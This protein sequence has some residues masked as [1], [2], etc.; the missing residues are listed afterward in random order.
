MKISDT[1]DN[2]VV[3]FSSIKVGNYPIVRIIGN[4]IDH[5]LSSPYIRSM[6][7][8]FEIFAKDSGVCFIS[9]DGR[10]TNMVIGYI[11]YHSK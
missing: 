7:R 10:E 11:N 4:D 9:N 1:N 5:V 8:G 6:Y 2:M 3:V